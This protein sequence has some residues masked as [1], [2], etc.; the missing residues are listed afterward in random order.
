MA[1]TTTVLRDISERFVVPRKSVTIA[2]SVYILLHTLVSD[3][4]VKPETAIIAYL[5]MAYD[6]LARYEKFY[7]VYDK[8]DESRFRW[9][10]KS[11]CRVSGT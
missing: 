6:K 1:Q 2:A 9:D 8:W 4:S 11:S 7:G 10:G 5:E 3:P